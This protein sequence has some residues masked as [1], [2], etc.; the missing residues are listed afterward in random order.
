MYP[1]LN[2]FM[3]QIKYYS[4]YQL[5]LNTKLSFKIV[6]HNILLVFLRYKIYFY[7]IVIPE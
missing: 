7:D 1:I 5:L 4:I 2:I 6:F 3:Q